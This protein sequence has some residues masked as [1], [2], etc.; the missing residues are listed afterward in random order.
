MAR[1]LEIPAVVGMKDITTSVKNGDTLIVDGNE[2]IVIINPDEETLRKYKSLYEEFQKEKEELK[3]LINVKT[4]G[5]SGKAIEI[6][7]N[8][9]KLKM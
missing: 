6:S 2:G 8:I 4:I 9:G 1:T 3:K 7:G 5:K